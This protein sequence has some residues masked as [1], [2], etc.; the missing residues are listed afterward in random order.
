MRIAVALCALAALVL[1]PSGARAASAGEEPGRAKTSPAPTAVV[2]T[3]A[4]D[5]VW[6]SP[7]RLSELT[8][9]G[10]HVAVVFSPD[11]SVPTNRLFYERLG[12]LYLE[13]ASWERVLSRVEAF[14]AENPSRAVETLFIMS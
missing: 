9:I 10:E 7:E 14:N 2:V 6:P 4:V 3:T 11:F 5:P 8:S 12:F 1:A 13:D